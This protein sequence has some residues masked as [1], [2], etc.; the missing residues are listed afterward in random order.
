MATIGLVLLT[1]MATLVGTKW[2]PDAAGPTA[3]FVSFTAS[4][5]EGNGGCNSFSGPYKLDGDKIS[6]GPLASTRMACEPAVMD[7]E[8]AWFTLL[9]NAA[10]VEMGDKQ[11]ILKDK[12]GARIG[13]LKQR[14]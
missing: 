14:D 4:T 5:A 12:A 13:V 1:T 8:A 11:L 9:G 3:Q 6:I 7:A 2:G 10:Q